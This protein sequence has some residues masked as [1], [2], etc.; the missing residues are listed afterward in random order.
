MIQ[1]E[2]PEFLEF[3][4]PYPSATQDLARTLRQ[5]LLEFLPPCV[6]IIWDATNTVGISVG[7][8]EKNSDHFIH[9]P[10]YTSYVNLGFSHGALLD[11]PEGR[12]QGTGA[13][14]RHIRISDADQLDD[15]YVQR[16]IAQAHQAARQSPTPVEPRSLIR[17]MSGPKRRPKPTSA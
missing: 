4:A 1:P 2:P 8:T 11:D 13:R 9:L 17:V 14:I 3:L 10:A 15:P 16:L 6:E 7:F 5:R 12:L